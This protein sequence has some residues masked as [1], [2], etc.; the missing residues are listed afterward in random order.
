MN[1][2]AMPFADCLWFSNGACELYEAKI[3]EICLDLDIP[4]L[5][6]FRML[7]NN[8]KWN[9]F[10]E[11]DGIHL[12]TNGHFWIYQKIMEWK[13]LLEWAELESTNTVT[14]I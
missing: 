11:P 9:T 8:D 3:E 5:P 6:T 1:E 2:D 14:S 13:L 7:T 10:I 4:F 12:N